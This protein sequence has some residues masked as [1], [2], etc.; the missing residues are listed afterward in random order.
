MILI[1]LLFSL[2]YAFAL[3]ST[4][5]DPQMLQILLRSGAY[6]TRY[7]AAKF[8]VAETRKGHPKW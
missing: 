7:D 8:T 6:R 2:L 3:W 4:K 5:H 1:I